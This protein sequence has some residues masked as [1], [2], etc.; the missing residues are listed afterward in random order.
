MGRFG[1]V[2]A[3]SATRPVPIGFGIFQP[4]AVREMWKTGGYS[5]DLGRV[6]QANREFLGDFHL[7]D[8]KQNLKK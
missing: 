3:R 7:N 1:R 5:S 4:V 6:G 8:Q 2:L